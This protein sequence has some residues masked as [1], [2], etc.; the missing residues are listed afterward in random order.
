MIAALAT[1][2]AKQRQVGNPSDSNDSPVHSKKYAPYNAV[3]FME[4]SMQNCYGFKELHQVKK[5][6][7]S[8]P[9]YLSADKFIICSCYGST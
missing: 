9:Q 5:F 1:E 2:L 4:A 6:F 8:L 7:H 3:H